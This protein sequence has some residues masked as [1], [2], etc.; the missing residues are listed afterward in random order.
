[1]TENHVEVYEAGDSQD[2]HFL[3]N[4]LADAGIAAI[5][6]GDAADAAIGDRTPFSS[7]PK[8]WVPPSYVERARP[9]IAEYQQHLIERAESG[10]SESED[11][12]ADAN[13]EPFCYHCGSPVAAGQTPC[14][15]CGE[16]LE[17][18]AA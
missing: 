4:L 13:A 6:V 5:V 3:R 14:P 12:A 16:P 10:V 15:A 9:I 2:A 7:P 17:W 11:S 8:V 1:M 18:P